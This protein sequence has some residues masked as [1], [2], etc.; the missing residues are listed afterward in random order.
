MFHRRFLL[1]FVALANFAAFAQTPTTSSTVTREFAFPAIGLGASET[2]Q[3]NVINTATGSSASC[4]GTISFVSVPANGAVGS[5]VGTSSDFT[6]LA[7]G[8]SFSGKLVGSGSRQE[9]R[10]VV[11]LTISSNAPCSL[12]ISMETYDSTLGVT[13]AFLGTGQLAGFGPGPGH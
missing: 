7:A 5:A 6:A 11:T 2:A 1:I 8:A 13:H 4:T 3:V 12:A 9:I 10:G